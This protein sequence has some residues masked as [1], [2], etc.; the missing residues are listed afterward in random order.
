MGVPTA[1]H[2]SCEKNQS[3]YVYYGIVYIK[4]P[5][6]QGIVLSIPLFGNKHE[7]KKKDHFFTWACHEIG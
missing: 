7:I 1:S 2:V 4:I 3:K 6:K 5:K